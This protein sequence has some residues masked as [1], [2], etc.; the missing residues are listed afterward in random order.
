MNYFKKMVTFLVVLTLGAFVLSF[1]KSTDKITKASV[2]E[3]KAA[4]KLRM[5]M[6]L[7]RMF[8][9]SDGSDFGEIDKDYEALNREEYAVWKSVKSERAAAKMTELGYSGR[10]VEVI[11]NEAETFVGSV[12]EIALKKFGVAFNKLSDEQERAAI[13]EAEK[14]LGVKN[15]AANAAIAP[16]QSCDLIG[17]PY[18]TAP[19][20]GGVWW[21][22]HARKINE[23]GEIPCDYEYHY[24]GYRDNLSFG[25]W[26]SQQAGNNGYCIF[27]W[28]SGSTHMLVGWGSV[29]VYLSGI[30]EIFHGYLNW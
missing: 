14:A 18:V 21:Y 27:N 15:K 9:E 19:G 6:L 20:S 1:S 28:A 3:T 12:E 2:K 24:S 8:A 17:Y 29:E 4:M 30:P 23:P 7:D 26:I 13:Q 11:L 10:T 16:E 22:T 5:S 25:N